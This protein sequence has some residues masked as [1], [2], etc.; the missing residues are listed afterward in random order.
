MTGDERDCHLK[1]ILKMDIVD[2][3]SVV[4]HVGLLPLFEIRRISDRNPPAADVAVEHST[5]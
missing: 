2:T 5:Y 4:L 3:G 1:G